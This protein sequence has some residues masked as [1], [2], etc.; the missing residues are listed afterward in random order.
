MINDIKKVSFSIIVPVYNVEDYL[1]ECID[2][3]LAQEHCEME[4]LLVD[5]GST[6]SSGAI[7]DQYAKKDDRITVMHKKNG[8]P[9]EARNA[10]IHMARND[11]ILFVDSDDYIA[12]N[13][14]ENIQDVILKQNYPDLVFLECMKI[15]DNCEMCIPMQDG[16]SEEV[17]T[18][19]GDVLRKY[20]ADLPKYPASPCAKAIKRTKFADGNFDFVKGIY[21]EDLEWAVNVFLTI[22]SAAYCNMPHYFYRQ[23][24]NGSISNSPNK[25]MA[26]DVLSTVEKWYEKGCQSDKESDRHLI[27]SLMEYVFRF[28]CIHYWRVPKAERRD[29]VRRVKHCEKVLGTRK[30]R[31]SK[32]ISMVY[33]IFGIKITGCLLMT[34]LE[35]RR[36]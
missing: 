1:K 7:C 36:E 14:L 31:N 24:R 27:Y 25:K 10:G 19:T 12:E 30:D 3:I 34:Y 33:R 23:Q 4:I 18:M 32:I 8:G 29:Y 26:Y 20:I 6:D 35:M 22:E 9:S 16:V 15:Y 11:Y 2:S 13:S 5:D 21:C 17:N 28:L